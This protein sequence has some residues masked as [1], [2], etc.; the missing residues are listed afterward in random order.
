MRKEQKAFRKPVSGPR[1]VRGRGGVDAQYTQR[2]QKKEE[3]LAELIEAANDD[4]SDTRKELLAFVASLVYVVVSTHTITARDLL[5]LTPVKLP[6]VGVEVPLYSFFYWTPPAI[7]AVHAVVLL[8]LARIREKLGAARNAIDGFQADREKFRLRVVSNFLAQRIV[9]PPPARARHALLWTVYL[10]VVALA[11]LLSLLFITYRAL[12]LH[13]PVLTFWQNI[14]FAADFALTTYLA[15]RRWIV[16]AT[17]LGI[18]GVPMTFLVL[19]VPDS[20]LEEW[21]IKGDESGVKG[22]FWSR[23]IDS[24]TSGAKHWVFWPTAV[25]L[26]SEL[27]PVTKR[28]W[29]FG[30]TRNIVLVDDKPPV[31]TIIRGGEPASPD[32]G[33]AAKSIIKPPLS[34]VGRNLRYAIFDRSDLSGADF[35][36]ADLYGASLLSADLSRAQFGCLYPEWDKSQENKGC[37]NVEHA[38]LQGVDLRGAKF[39]WRDNKI[40]PL[41]GVDLTSARMEGVNLR[42]VDLSRATLSGAKLVGAYLDFARFIGARLDDADLTGVR[43]WGTDFSFSTM[44]RAHLDGADFNSA[45]R[46]LV[47]DMRG[48][49]LFRTRLSGAHLGGA[50]LRRAQV[51]ETEPP[52]KEALAWTDL[53]E[54]V[55]KPFDNALVQRLQRVID[56]NPNLTVAAVDEDAPVEPWDQ[57]LKQLRDAA[58]SPKRTFEAKPAWEAAKKFL[59]TKKDDEYAYSYKEVTAKY[60]CLSSSYVKAIISPGP[61]WMYLGSTTYGWYDYSYDSSYIDEDNP[62]KI[63]QDS[64]LALLKNWPSIW[65]QGNFSDDYDDTGA[66]PFELFDLSR[67]VVALDGDP[68]KCPATRGVLQDVKRRLRDAAVRQQAERVFP[69]CM[70]LH[71]DAEVADC[72]PHGGG[73]GVAPSGADA[74]LRMTW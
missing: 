72:L 13:E 35:V 57:G 47:A 19:C 73:P 10:V 41:A 74:W 7:L 43:A 22:P 45:V 12:P 26:E 6:F 38:R 48:V 49:S 25:L 56:D 21:A 3:K 40:M 63:I 61:V 33:G 36:A 2:Q 42:F 52:R 27:D 29:F 5:A 64:R 39:R 18:I 4:V 20:P 16:A 54:L 51:W 31:A 34:L 62:G 23:F 50:L 59:V 14:V 8:R 30:L 17:V 11:P 58:K 1:P 68:E 28:P 53:D 37:T 24:S 70:V 69:P 9:T 32:R 66:S 55:V 60:A 46:F 71:A 67:L 15:A 44:K 65:N